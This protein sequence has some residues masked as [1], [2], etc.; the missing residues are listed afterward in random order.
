MRQIKLVR[1]LFEFYTVSMPDYRRYFTPGVTCFFTVNLKN[2]KSD[3]LIRRINELRSAWKR[4][5]ETQPFET[6]AI[7]ILPD[8]LHCILRLPE[9]DA[10]Y[11][12]LWMRIK[13][14]FS[15]AVPK[16]E[17]PAVASGKRERGIWQRRYWD[18]IIRDGRDFENHVNYIHGN[19]V[20]HGY[21]DDP[22]DWPYSSWHRF[23]R[24]FGVAYAPG[25][26]DGQTFGE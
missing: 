2:R 15:R 19:P 14:F 22:D 26:R 11:A 10:N 23:K 7:C 20:K 3:L 24:E 25:W 1:Y 17:D 21:V 6:L 5:G 18:H 12:L 4:A 8:H 16:A 13:T 9:D